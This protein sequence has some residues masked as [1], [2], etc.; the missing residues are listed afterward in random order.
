MYSDP[1]TDRKGVQYIFRGDLTTF[2][3]YLG[4][5]VPCLSGRMVK[6]E[7]FVFGVFYRRPA[8]CHHMDDFALI[9]WA[10]VWFVG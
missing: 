8:T 4:V 7:H 3:I 6:V 10:L 2:S 9:S 5:H 1:Q